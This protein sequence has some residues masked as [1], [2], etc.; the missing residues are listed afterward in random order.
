MRLVRIALYA[1]ILVAT[2]F[3][4]TD[5][6]GRIPM[7]F[8]LTPIEVR[9]LSVATTEYVADSAGTNMVDMRVTVEIVARDTMAGGLQLRQFHLIGA[10]GRRFRPYASSLLFGVDGKLHLA[11]GDT[12]LGTLLFALPAD[13]EPEELWWEP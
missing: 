9:A 7:A 6:R 12:L 1:A 5:L 13:E 11:P 4:V 8:G 10:D 3:L 2:Y